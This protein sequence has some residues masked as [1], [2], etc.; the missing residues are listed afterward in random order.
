MKT[1]TKKVRKSH[2]N[3]DFM[4]RQYSKLS[5]AELSERIEELKGKIRLGWKAEM[6]QELLGICLEVQRKA[7]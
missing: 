4:F 2:F 6:F 3:K 5:P 1:L 7:A